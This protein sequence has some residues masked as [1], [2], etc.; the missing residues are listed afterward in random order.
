MIAFE[1]KDMTCGHCVSTITKAVR[2]ADKDAKVEIDLA[3]HRVQI[4]PT[5]TNAAELSDAI[6]EAGYTPVE[7]SA[8]TTDAPTVRKKGG[9]CCG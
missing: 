2:A 3:T 5:E 6:K 1:V 8:G 7:V 4:E 9:C